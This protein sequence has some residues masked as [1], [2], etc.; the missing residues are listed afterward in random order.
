MKSNTGWENDGNG[1]NS[2]AFAGL[3]GG[4]RDNF[5]DF[6]NI[7]GYGDWWSSSEANTDNAWYRY[8]YG[9]GGNVNRTNNYKR[10]GF[11]VRCL[12]D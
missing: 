2:S 10:N 9:S 1:T 11:S 7:G 5:G 6:T 12:R 8:L 3:P 4:Y